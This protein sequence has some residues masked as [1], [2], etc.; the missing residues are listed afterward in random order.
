MLIRRA[1]ILEVESKVDAW[2]E[3]TS[4]EAEAAAVRRLNKAALGN[5]VYPPF[6]SYLRHFVWLN[7]VDGAG[8]GPRSGA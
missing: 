2:Y 1:N 7:G 6:G 3:A 5:V 8:Q 4:F